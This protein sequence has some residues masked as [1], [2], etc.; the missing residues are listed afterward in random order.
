ML[1]LRCPGKKMAT[2]GGEDRR[3]VVLA[4]G[5]QAGPMTTRQLRDRAKSGELHPTDSVRLSD[6]DRWVL[7][8][9]VKGLFP[10]WLSAEV[11]DRLSNGQSVDDLTAVPDELQSLSLD[12][13]LQFEAEAPTNLQVMEVAE[14]REQEEG[15]PPNR[16]SGLLVVALVIG[17]QLCALGGL[18]LAAGKPGGA[19]ALVFGIPFTALGIVGW[20]NSRQTAERSIWNRDL[21]DINWR[22]I[23][24]IALVVTI[25]MAVVLLINHDKL[26]KPAKTSVAGSVTAERLWSDFSDNPAAAESRWGNGK[27]VVV[28]GEVIA[29]QNYGGGYQVTLGRWQAPRGQYSDELP[30]PKGQ[31][32]LYGKPIYYVDCIFPADSNSEVATLQTGQQISV[33]GRV[34]GRLIAVQLR[35]CRM[36]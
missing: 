18:V 4:A 33:E 8:Y 24:A 17:V 30:L 31:E 9:K 20:W 22:P 10:A 19:I 11:A 34:S 5:R 16:A 32:R 14:P 35:E 6:S 13:L 36:R 25:L 15:S 12:E 29:I 2:T 27:R 23:Q 7:A 1:I 28:R 26:N 21:N 3:F